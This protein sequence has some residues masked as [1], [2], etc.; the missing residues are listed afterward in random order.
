MKNEVAWKAEDS[1]HSLSLLSMSFSFDASLKQKQGR[2]MLGG[3]DWVQI[4]VCFVGSWYV[5]IA[6]IYLVFIII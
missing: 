1:P 4:C 6:M 5:L 2:G 3:F